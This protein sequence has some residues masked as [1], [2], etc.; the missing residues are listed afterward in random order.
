MTAGINKQ[1]VLK[2]PVK[3]TAENIARKKFCGKL[4]Y[5]KYNGVCGIALR[6]FTL[7]KNLRIENLLQN[8][9]VQ[10]FNKLHVTNNRCYIF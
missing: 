10:Y 9:N 4:T 5:P 1:S 8:F 6:L 2:L 3:E 7:V